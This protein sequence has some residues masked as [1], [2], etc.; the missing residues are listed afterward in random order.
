M[1][2]YSKIQ[3]NGIKVKIIWWYNLKMKVTRVPVQRGNSQHPFR[4]FL[5]LRYGN[6]VTALS[7]ESSVQQKRMRQK[8]TTYRYWHELHYISII[9][10][11]VYSVQLGLLIGVIGNYA[12]YMVG[13]FVVGGTSVPLYWGC[14]CLFRDRVIFRTARACSS[15]IILILSWH[16][17]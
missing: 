7:T 10:M 13:V 14:C 12:Y 1:Q 2:L 16:S 3:S 5:P 6:T 15:F 8:I 9:K 11:I 17:E 4:A